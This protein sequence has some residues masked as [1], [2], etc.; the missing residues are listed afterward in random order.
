MI[1]RNRILDL[2]GVPMIL[3]EE[4]YAKIRASDKF[5]GKF[6]NKYRGILSVERVN[7]I[8]YVM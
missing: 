4:R 6:V 1:L 5:V 8:K 2:L 7:V 3:M